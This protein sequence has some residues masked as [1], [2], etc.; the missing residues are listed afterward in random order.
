M[1]GAA[2]TIHSAGY[3]T[4]ETFKR[5]ASNLLDAL[6]RPAPWLRCVSNSQNTKVQ[7]DEVYKDV[8]FW[9]PKRACAARAR[10]M[11]AHWTSHTI[12]HSLLSV[13]SLSGLTF[14]DQGCGVRPRAAAVLT[15]TLA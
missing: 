9:C 1:D 3:I 15:L 8:G 2:S 4:C 13:L 10:I 12:I 14:T 11:H 6:T 7:Q 5:F